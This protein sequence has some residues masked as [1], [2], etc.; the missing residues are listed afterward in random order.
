[1]PRKNKSN[2]LHCETSEMNAR[3][4]AKLETAPKR[5]EMRFNPPFDRVSI[6]LN[7]FLIEK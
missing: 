4:Y 1:V 3:Y 7:L 2:I 5:C 6:I